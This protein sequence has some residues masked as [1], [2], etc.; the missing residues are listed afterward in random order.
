MRASPETH[1]KQRAGAWTHRPDSSGIQF[2]SEVSTY[3]PRVPFLP[4]ALAL[5]LA[6]DDPMIWS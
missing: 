6:L 2:V 5:P 3:R 4:L 1:D